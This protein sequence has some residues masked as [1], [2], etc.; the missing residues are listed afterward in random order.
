M[1][2]AGDGTE[3]TRNQIEAAPGVAATV[4]PVLRRWYPPAMAAAGESR[5]SSTA[6]MSYRACAA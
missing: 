5:E 2:S 1:T 4:R 6:V 3:A